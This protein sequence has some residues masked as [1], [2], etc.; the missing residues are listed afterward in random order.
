MTTLLDTAL[1]YHRA[2]L[3]VLPNDPAK[4]YPAMLTGWQQVQPTEQDIRRWFTNGRHAIGVRD[5]EGLDFDNKG[6]PDAATLYH[7]W[8]AL[9]EQLRPG[10]VDRLLCERTPSGGFHLVWRCEDIAGNQKLATR[11]PTPAELEK[12]P[13]LTA[14][15]L[16]ETRGRG[17]QFQ[18]APSPGYEVQRGS[19]TQLPQI[20]AADR[21][22]LIDCARALT[23]TDKRTIDLLG[24]STGERAGDRY[25]AEAGDEAFRLLEDAG[26]A[27][28][29]ERG[30][31]K[32]LTRPDK[33]AGVSATWG[34]VA[35]DVLYV[36]S[37]NAAPFE[38]NRAYSPFA[39]YTELQHGGDYKRAARALW[40]R[41]EG[42]PATATSGALVPAS[43][44]AHA[45]PAELV[46][47]PSAPIDVND[48][49]TMERR[50][51]VWYAPGFL[52][53]GLG[54][55]VG[56]PNVGKT[57]LAAQLAIAVARGDKWMGAVQTQQ[58][59]V[60]YLG[61]EYSAQELIPLFDISRCGQDIPRGQLLIKTIED[62][63]PTTAEEALSGLEWY[64][65]VLGV[66]LIIIDVLTAFLPP[67][68][69]KQNV[70]RGD[71]SELKPYHRL[72]LQYN[73]AIL[74]VWHASKR[75]A[76]PKLMYNG[77]TGM[78]AAAA[79]RVTMY[80]DQEQR[81]RIA[82]FARM[83]DR[84]DW[85]LAQEKRLDGG[86]RWIVA[87]ANPEPVCSPTELQIFRCLKSNAEKARPLG[88]TTI[89]ELTAI[90]MG[91]VK[92]ALSR[93]FSANIIHQPKT[94]GGYYVEVATDATFATNATGETLATSAT[95]ATPSQH[96]RV[97]SATILQPSKTASGR[98]ETAGLQGLQGS[99]DADVQQNAFGTPG[100]SLDHTEPNKTT[101]TENG[102]SELNRSDPLTDDN[103]PVW[104]DVPRWK[105]SGLRLYMRSNKESDQAR[106]REICEDL[107]IDYDD[108]WRRIKEARG[109]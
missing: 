34:Y 105:A 50:P 55:L 27:V 41:Y 9:V 101:G 81:V 104:A 13:K 20:S 84:V 68:K 59:K 15:A 66:R 21:G 22:V 56:Q 60:L 65:R 62:D 99:T 1:A 45:R 69:F 91:T 5:V 57:P 79:S 33:A 94:G 14:V 100:T 106:A 23:R 88:P 75:E 96:E 46:T 74:G 44:G 97:A 63:F 7:E 64:M 77:S 54:L 87:D 40:E 76:D 98:S 109:Q 10:L 80:Q 48:L 32:Y 16:I 108:L 42:T 92:S 29:M 103:H 25:N 26:W 85:A 67:E 70:Y 35:P 8:A 4:K 107:G 72:A 12:S 11:P 39:I 52:R 61:M 30:T 37:S 49:L 18:V 24:K 58:A 2:G 78:W 73:A 19:W 17:G 102:Y 31:V 43:E 28:A 89:A 38:P 95:L 3:V 47:P 51:T 86:R 90:P 82:S 6:A 93:M 71:Y 83:A 36:F 53:E